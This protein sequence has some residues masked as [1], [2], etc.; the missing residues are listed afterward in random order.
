MGARFCSR[1]GKPDGPGNKIRPQRT[2]CWP[3]LED[4]RR[5]HERNSIPE[6]SD[7]P[8]TR[9]VVAT[10]DPTDVVEIRPIARKTRRVLF[11]PDCHHPNIHLKAWNLML[12]A[13]ARWQPE[14]IVVLGDFLDGESLSLHEA[15][16]PT[17]LDFSTEVDAVGKAL[18][19]L[20]D[21]GASTKIYI[22][23]NHEQRLSRFLARRAPALY[24]SMSLPELLKLRET[25][26][27]WVPYRK[28]VKLGKLHLTHDTG[29][30]GANAHRFSARAFMGSA[31]IGHTHRM[32]YEVTGRFDS[33]PYLACMLGWLGDAEKAAKYLHEAKSAEWVHGF[34]I[35]LLEEDTG[36][37]HVQPVPVVAGRVFIGGELV[38]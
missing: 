38:D 35:G 9:S 20:D 21:L 29:S 15:D 16:A 32:A 7:F 22:E 14:V 31:I 1:C 11:V 34:G 17:E 3:C 30:A 18:T 19:Q 28:S 23:G 25:G 10:F 33:T 6:E 12:R 26:W 27:Q 24:R 4:A 37:V 5:N 8:E 36:Y 13:A 2:V